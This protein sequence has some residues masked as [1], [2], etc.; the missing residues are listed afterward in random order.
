MNMEVFM[1]IAY[2]YCPVVWRSQHAIGDENWQTYMLVNFATG[3]MNKIGYLNDL[4]KITAYLYKCWPNKNPDQKIYTDARI[5]DEGTI[6][7]VHPIGSWS[8]LYSNLINFK[9]V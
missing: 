8:E 7:D 4:D 9:F 2:G 3:A 1:I 6:H 5:T